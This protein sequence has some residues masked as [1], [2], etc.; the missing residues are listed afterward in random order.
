MQRNYSGDVVLVGGLDCLAKSKSRLSGDWYC[1]IWTIFPLLL[2]RKINITLTE[3]H[4][5]DSK[6]ASAN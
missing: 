6:C 4:T 2:S 5:W 1:I 3:C